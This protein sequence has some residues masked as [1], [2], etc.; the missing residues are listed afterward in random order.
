MRLEI[1]SP[2]KTIYR[3]EIEQVNLPGQQGPFMVL[4]LHAPIISTLTAGNV[5]YLP[6]GKSAE[7]DKVSVPIIS[8][9][10]EVKEDVISVCVEVTPKIV[11]EVINNENEEVLESEEP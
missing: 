11:E 4:H 9:F 2:E 6:K 10:V 1:L 7:S 3:G 8:G 5:V